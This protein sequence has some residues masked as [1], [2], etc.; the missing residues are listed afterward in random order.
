MTGFVCNKR[1][2]PIR[3]TSYEL[4]NHAIFLYIH[5]TSIISTIYISLITRSV[6]NLALAISV[7]L[8]SIHQIDVQFSD[9]S[10]CS[11]IVL[12]MS[13]DIA[14]NQEYDVFIHICV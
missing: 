4:I 5:C 3:N 11:T 2:V 8:C 7:R 9:L 13:T 10:V 14:C 1:V 6:L 12:W